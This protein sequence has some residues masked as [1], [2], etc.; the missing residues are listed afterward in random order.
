MSVHFFN[1]YKVVYEPDTLVVKDWLKV[2]LAFLYTICSDTNINI[3]WH[4]VTSCSNTFVGLG[5][6]DRSRHG[7]AVRL[8]VTRVK[9]KRSL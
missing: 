4:I 9:G 5:W 2:R 6:V 3:M 7:P 1:S 8:D